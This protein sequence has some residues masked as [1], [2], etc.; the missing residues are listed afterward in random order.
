MFCSSIVAKLLD[1]N[2]VLCEGLSVASLQ[3]FHGETQINGV[4]F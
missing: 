2:L 1:W 4:C 3:Y